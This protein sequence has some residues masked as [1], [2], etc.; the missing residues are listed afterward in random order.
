M[1]LLTCPNCGV[2]LRLKP[3]MMRSLKEFPCTKCRTKIPIP[4]EAGEAVATPPVAPVEK[5]PEAAAKPVSAPPIP[6]AK[7]A[8]PPAPEVKPATPPAPEPKHEPDEKPAKEETPAPSLAEGRLAAVEKELAG[9]RNEVSELRSII[10]E[11][12][13]GQAEAAAHAATA[14]ERLGKR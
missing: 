13:D 3:A 8:T 11:Y 9:L 2:K 12:T 10:S 5:P 7:P 14:L 1:S 4:Q 6:E